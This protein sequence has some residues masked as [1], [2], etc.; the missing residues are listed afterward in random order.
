LAKKKKKNYTLVLS[1]AELPTA[2]GLQV[3]CPKGHLI[4]GS[5]CPKWS[6]A[7]IFSPDANPNPN[8]CLYVSDK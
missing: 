4:D 5:F 6:C 7:E 8:L 3:T 2:K 1:N